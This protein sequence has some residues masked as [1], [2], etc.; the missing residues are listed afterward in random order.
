MEGYRWREKDRNHWDKRDSTSFCH[1][2]Q[3][4]IS[5]LIFPELHEAL[6]QI[7]SV[8]RAEWIRQES[9][10]WSGQWLLSFT[11]KDEERDGSNVAW[12]LVIVGIE[13]NMNGMDGRWK[14]ELW[15]DWRTEDSLHAG[16][17]RRQH[18]YHLLSKKK[19]KLNI[20]DFPPHNKDQP[21]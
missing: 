3:L 2:L 1:L 4:L 12:R 17:W 5:L 13:I 19:A 16:H 18:Y 21:F 9:T 11:R 20:K 8:R 6:N 15:V 10:E 7:F 14:L